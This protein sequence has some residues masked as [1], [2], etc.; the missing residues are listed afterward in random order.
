M[1]KKYINPT[2]ET[3]KVAQSLPIATSDP[4]VSI[5]KGGSVSAGS[6]DVKQN[7]YSVWDDDW[8]Q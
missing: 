6:V 8:N 7:N 3:V 1:K 5:N 2:M 4:K